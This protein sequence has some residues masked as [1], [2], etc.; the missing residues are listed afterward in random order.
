[1]NTSLAFVSAVKTMPSFGFLLLC[2]QAMKIILIFFWKFLK[3]KKQHT[4]Y[5]KDT[6]QELKM[7]RKEYDKFVRDGGRTFTLYLSHPLSLQTD[8]AAQAES[9]TYKELFRRAMEEYINTHHP[10]LLLQTGTEAHD[11]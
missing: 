11:A 3:K 6:F 9:R 8:R 10:D 1:M 4:T 5:M 2:S 7:N